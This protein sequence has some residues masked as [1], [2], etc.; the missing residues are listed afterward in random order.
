MFSI[1]D[2]LIIAMQKC[3]CEII[4]M[5][6]CFFVLYSILRISWRY[7]PCRS[8][9]RAKERESFALASKHLKQVSWQYHH[10]RKSG[11]WSPVVN[12]RNKDAC[13][14]DVFAIIPVRVGREDLHGG[15]V[16][17]E[18]RP[19]VSGNVKHRI[20]HHML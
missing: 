5:I 18:P 16:L 9:V 15:I 13:I 11:S 12:E 20:L 2:F 4:T 7:M 6:P 19:V 10:F 17:Q 1:K 3:S 8:R 14:R